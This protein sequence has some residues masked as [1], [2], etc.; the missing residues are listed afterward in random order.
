MLVQMKRL[1]QSGQFPNRLDTKGN[2]RFGRSKS[3]PSSGEPSSA[4]L[5]ELEGGGLTELDR[6]YSVRGSAVSG[7]EGLGGW[8][9]ELDEHCGAS[10]G[11]SRVVALPVSGVLQGGFD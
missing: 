3:K 8:F 2:G 4:L 1:P 7:F 10:G 6:L 9:T 11:K 5:G